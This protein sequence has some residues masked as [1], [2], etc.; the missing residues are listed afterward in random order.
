MFDYPADLWDRHAVFP[1]RFGDY[2]VLEVLFGNLQW[3]QRLDLGDLGPA[4]HDGLAPLEV[5]KIIYAGLVSE[6]LAQ[7]AS[8]STVDIEDDRCPDAPKRMNLLGVKLPQILVCETK[9]LSQK[10]WFC[11]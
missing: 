10:A 4:S 9:S 6:T 7:M 11:R 3:A 5:D 1:S 2:P 8:I